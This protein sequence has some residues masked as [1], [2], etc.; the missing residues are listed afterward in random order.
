[1]S[2]LIRG[3]FVN[4]HLSEGTLGKTSIKNAFVFLPFSESKVEFYLLAK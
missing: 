2:K 3:C 4:V 1:M